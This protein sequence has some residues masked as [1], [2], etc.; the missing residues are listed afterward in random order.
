[1]AAGEAPEVPSE[2]ETLRAVEARQ[3]ALPRSFY[4]R[5]ATVVA[6]DI[7]GRLFVRSLP[8]ATLVGR[9]VEAEAYQ[10]DDPA[11]HSFRGLTPRT[12]VMFGP[13]GHLYVYF[14]YGM[15]YCMNVV[16]GKDGDGSAVLLRAAEPLE[17]IEVMRQHRGVPVDRL[18]CSGPARLTQA[19][20]IGREQNGVD[21]VTSG[22]LFLA[23]GKRLSP[24]K[25][26]NGPRIGI[27]SATERPWRFYELGN[28]HVSRGPR[29][30]GGDARPIEP[31]KQKVRAK[32]KETERT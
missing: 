4:A 17:G 22:E 18:L 20:R 16:T 13:P 28:R 21:L 15:H 19:F 14:T 11:S 12:R 27:R 6:R 24:S 30:S 25:L 32:E 23:P 8:E 9:I 5:P 3:E 1:M 26:G 10:E 31:V 29:T 2:G 7:L